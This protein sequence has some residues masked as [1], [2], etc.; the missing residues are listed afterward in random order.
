MPSA[1]APPRAPPPKN[2]TN[3]A[4]SLRRLASASEKVSSIDLRFR[5]A[6]SSWISSAVPSIAPDFP[7]PFAKEEAIRPSAEFG[8]GDLDAACRAS[9]ATIPASPKTPTAA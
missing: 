3:P 1:P 5:M 4:L 2:P 7:N 8:P 6:I 9:K